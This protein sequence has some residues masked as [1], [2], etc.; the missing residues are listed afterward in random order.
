MWDLRIANPFGGV[1]ARKIL[2]LV[3]AALVAALSYIMVAAP[4]AHAADAQWRGNALVYDGK[5]Y[6][7]TDGSGN[8]SEIPANA[9]TYVFTE[10]S[11]GKAHFVYFEPNADPLTSPAARYIVYD[12]TPPNTFSNPSAP[13]SITVDPQSANS[14]STTSCDSSFTGGVGWIIC[15]V[16]NFLAKAMDWLYGIL[17]GFMSVRPVQTTQENALYRAWSIMRNFANV[18]FVIAFL[19]IIYSQVS[20]VGLSSYGIKKLLPRLIIAAVLVNISYWICAIAID[21]SNILGYSIQD[22]F[23]MIRNNLV[24][25]EGNSWDLLNFESITG[26]IL[27]GGTAAVAGGIGIYALIG[28]TVGSAI[29]ML[30]PILLGVLLAVIVALLI[31]AA[32]QAIITV[33]VILAPLAFVAYLLPNTEKYFEKWRD[34]GLTMLIMF[35]MFSIIFG[36]S[37]LAGAVI[38]QNADF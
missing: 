24:G 35:P 22:L 5:Q 15:P 31:L 17:S 30:L 12:Y 9:P 32:R 38:I 13:Q 6:I 28:G 10:P 36:G 34:L 2:M 4:T 25:Q 1:S 3:T 8:P 16:T 27:S 23:I 18:A 11:A 20:S 29:Y 14:E 21:I 37:Q 26:F 7:R 33:L 19:I